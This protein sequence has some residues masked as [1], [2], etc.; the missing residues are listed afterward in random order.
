[1]LKHGNLLSTFML[2]LASR[3]PKTLPIKAV[4]GGNDRTGIHKTITRTIWFMV[5]VTCSARGL[6]IAENRYG[7]GAGVGAGAG[8]ECDAPC[9]I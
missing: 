2:F 6:R 3:V 5:R 7:C 4:G 1:M 8:L 9:S